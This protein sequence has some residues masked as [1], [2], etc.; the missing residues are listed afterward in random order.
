LF[1]AEDEEIL[2]AW[3]R[4]TYQTMKEEIFDKFK[5]LLLAGI[6]LGV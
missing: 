2:I 3:L 6:L 4:F 5:V 1:S